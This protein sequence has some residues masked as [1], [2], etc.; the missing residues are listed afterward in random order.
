MNEWTTQN[1]YQNFFYVPLSF[2]VTSI[3]SIF[4]ITAPQ[5][6]AGAMNVSLNVSSHSVMLSLMMFIVNDFDISPAATLTV[7]EFTL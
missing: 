1:G 7:V 5:A 6:E 3:E 4:P 2:I